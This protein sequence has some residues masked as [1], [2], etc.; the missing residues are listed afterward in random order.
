MSKVLKKVFK[1]KEKAF[2]DGKEVEREVELA[3]KIPT[4]LEKQK[5]RLVYAKAW[6][7][8]VEAGAIMREALDR[9]L[10][11][12]KLWDDLREKEWDRLRKQIIEGERKLK[13]GGNA[14]LTK[15]KARE[16]A[17]QI[18]DWR[19][20]MNDLL[21]ERNAVEMNT[22]DMIADNAQFN[23]LVAACTVYNN[24]GK[25]Y[26]TDNGINPDVNVFI[27][28]VGEQAAKDAASKFGEIYYNVPDSDENFLDKLPERKFLKEYGFADEKGRLID[29]KGRLIDREG[30]LI[31]ENER[32]INEQGEFVDSEG[33][34]VDEQGQYI[35]D[36][37]PFL[38]EALAG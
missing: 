16:L 24:T 28:R 13:M 22:A 8:A 21:S 32:Y 18:S 38:E 35:V 29:E 27:D 9:Y 30:R 26:F 37:A 36:F 7:E 10:R 3:I 20:E 6:R 14:G 17:L 4:A 23:Y 33:N 31:N 25:P 2:E 5:A 11:D 1:T 34:R 19:K 12:Q 15:Q